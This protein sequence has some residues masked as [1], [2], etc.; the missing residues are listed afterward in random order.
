MTK[1]ES[2]K[3]LV[4]CLASFSYQEVSRSLTCFNMQQKEW[5][6]QQ[7]RNLSNFIQTRTGPPIYFLPKNH[8]ATTLELLAESKRNLALETTAERKDEEEKTATEEGMEDVD[9][10]DST[11]SSIDEGT[12][13]D[14]EQGETDMDGDQS[15]DERRSD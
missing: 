2:N 8:N 7:K 14:R 10:R 6:R 13:G 3:R 11:K 9:N 4:E 1:T 15:R 5:Q 12:A